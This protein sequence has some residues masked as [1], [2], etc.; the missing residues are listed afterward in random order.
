MTASCQKKQD[1]KTGINLPSALEEVSGNEVIAD[2]NGIWM[3]NDS[4]DSPRLFYVNLKGKLIKKIYLDADNEDWEDIT[5]DLEG[6]LYVGDFGNNSNKREDLEILIVPHSALKSKDEIEVKRIKFNFEDQ[7][8]YPP[9]KKKLYFDCE[10]FFHFND[11]LYVFTKSRV[12]DDYGKTSV[13]KIPAKEGNHK[14][15]KIG[16]YNLGKKHYNWVTGADIRDDGKQVALL[17]QRDIW[18]FSD[19]EKDDFF[20]GKVSKIHFKHL[21]QKEGI[22]Y[23]NKDTLLV[24]DEDDHGRGGNLYTYIIPKP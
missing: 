18:L 1:V 14:A 8:K 6:N 21:T 10:A 11:N 5:S 2:S 13:Y 23:K 19:F 7:K 4:G 24:T 3:H 9:K 15:K 20:N 16:S 17:T 12:E 22:C